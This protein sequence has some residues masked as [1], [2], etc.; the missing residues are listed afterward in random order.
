MYLGRK[1]KVSFI[2]V[3]FSPKKWEERGILSPF[4]FFWVP[5]KGLKMQALRPKIKKMKN[6]K[7]LRICFYPNKRGYTYKQCRELILVNC[8]I[9]FDKGRKEKE[10]EEKEEKKFSDSMPRHFQG[11]WP[12]QKYEF[13]CIFLYRSLWFTLQSRASCCP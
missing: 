12:R 3:I 13:I 7:V 1:L 11:K 5:P 10:K 9:N 8:C 6:E 2:S 4:N